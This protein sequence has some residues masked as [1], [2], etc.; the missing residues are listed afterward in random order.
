MRILRWAGRVWTAVLVVTVALAGVALGL[1]LALPLFDAPPQLRQAQPPDGSAGVAAR[2]RLTLS[3]DRPMNPRSVERALQI[4][5]PIPW[6]ARWAG[7]R[8]TLTISPTEALLPDTDYRLLLAST[9]LSRQ[10]RPLAQPIEL[11]FH[12]AQ[13]PAVVAVLPPEA[14]AAVALD[15]PISIVFSR[16]IVPTDALLLPRA[17]PELRFDPPLAGAATWL[18][19]STVLFRPSAPLRPATRYHATL[20]ATL[21]DTS[22]GQLRSPYAWSFQTAAPSVL[23]VSPADG[24]R[25][26][27]PGA[28]LA[29]TLS[30]AIALDSLRA[31]LTFS[32]TI[33]GELR[34]EPLA[35][36]RQRIT[37]SPAAA[38]RPGTAYTAT[39][40]AG[41]APLEGNLPLQ[42]LS[43]GFSTAPQPGLVARFPG[44]GQTLPHGQEIR[45]V[46]TTPIDYSALRAQLRLDP[47]AG[48]L[49]LAGGSLEVRVS[50]ELR[51]ATVYTLTV[52]AELA[53]RNGVALGQAY[54]LRFITAPAGPTLDLPEA[55]AHLTYAL[56]SQPASLLLRR[57]NLTALDIELYRLDEATLVRI[58]SFAEGDWP[59]FQPERYGQPLLRAWRVPLAD[60]L[61]TAAE[62]RLPLA[63]A[64][65]APLPPGAYYVR[66]RSLEGPRADTVLL[67]SRTR[68]TLQAGAPGS[69][70]AAALVWATDIISATPIADLPIA[71]YQGGALLH[72]ATTDRQGIARFS[73]L[74]HQRPYIALAGGSQPSIAGA[75]WRDAT[76]DPQPQLFV[77]TDR[78]AYHPGEA[79]Q[80][81]GF[82]RTTSAISPT[83]AVPSP[84]TLSALLRSRAGGERIYHEALRT[85][86]TGA[87]SATV[88]LGFD[89]RP[90]EYI[91]SVSTGDASAQA[92]VVVQ[93]RAATLLQ[94]DI[95]A[96]ALLVGGDHVP[97][98]LVVR[99][100]EGLP[101]AGATI[102]WTLS[103]TREPFPIG[104]QF[105]F[106][107]DERA[108]TPIA[109]HSA[110]AAADINGRL[111]V[112]LADLDLAD[113]PLRYRFVAQASA[114]GGAGAV[115]VA[116]LLVAPA[117]RSAG[118]RL[119]SQIF[120]IGRPG[121]VE[122]LAI[123]AQNQP[124]PG[125]PL[126]VELYRRSWERSAGDP[127]AWVP[128]D[129]LVLNRRVVAGPDGRARL[130]L[131]IARGGAYR[132]RVSTPESASNAAY[133]AASLWVSAP[134][135]TGWGELPGGG[136][137]LITD[138]PAY[139][140]GD[141]ATL[142]LI[143]NSSPTTALL[144]QARVGGLVAEAR[145]LR[146]GEPFTL[147]IAPDDAPALDLAL[148]T[149]APPTAAPAG[150]AL[151]PLPIATARLPI[152]SDRHTLQ[153]TIAS[154]RA[155]YA[156]GATATLTITTADA[157]GAAVP[158]DVV[159]A[160]GDR[161]EASA[162][163]I[164]QAFAVGARPLLTSPAPPGALV[165]QAAGLP[166]RNLPPPAARTIAWQP[167]LRTNAA[168]V[169]TTTVQ[170]PRTLG[171][172]WAHAWAAGI[173]RFGQARHS[174]AITR[175][176]EVQLL[177]PPAFRAGDQVILALLLRNN[178]PA[179][180]ELAIE[181]DVTG[182]ELDAGVALARRVVVGPG[183][184][185]RVAWP[186]RVGQAGQLRV[187]LAVIAD[188]APIE[189]FAIAE[190]TLAAL[191]V[192]APSRMLGLLREYFDT[193]TGR[194]IDLAR[195]Q[196]GQ[197]VR[198]RLTLV[199]PRPQR[200]LV[201]D[202]ALPACATL[203][204]AERGSFDQVARP[205]GRLLLTR[206]S[207][208]PG[209]VQYEYLLRLVAPG[210][211]E[212]PPPTA[213]TAA[214]AQASGNRQR[215]VVADP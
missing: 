88:P 71:I 151:D 138:R 131:E 200:D 1:R 67:V 61:N 209:V 136:P 152:F 134:G 89:V 123:D 63:D 116:E 147:T 160:L 157:A 84:A 207:L 35:D 139:Q 190:P 87:F 42:P 112:T 91:L 50:A 176:V 202:E 23:A 187:G 96:P 58:S 165:G 213:R 101:M 149:A 166:N 133:S 46:F 75:N 155:D 115:G 111:L 206:A 26:V 210:S 97:I 183:V 118:L 98:E 90:G 34:A 144:T 64:Q 83:L 100:A 204:A 28:T 13:A 185:Q 179:P 39:L 114:P 177:R 103:A 140:P 104:E 193:Q 154:D 32:P 142:L 170:L 189:S 43:W 73:G 76:A 60:P 78:A 161:L 24:E 198:A 18:D 11:R 158:A 30:Q 81:A 135:F 180:R 41:A 201:I 38:L 129:Q 110:V 146:A 107:D 54:Q 159:L 145:A 3:F 69:A 36:G 117:E 192:A 65:G 215:L 188:G 15:S 6:V 106:G 121:A 164:E 4:V 22:G 49:R 153:V 212:A 17:L 47:P 172:L 14:S 113:V 186:A 124:A 191:P 80:L 74:A 44:E 194:P 94:I 37:L 197:I 178:G 143:A 45:L 205:P 181:L 127:P 99:G 16:T 126:R 33:A 120:P 51:A 20:A 5:P 55:P 167:R 9:A 196:V 53:D 19:Q 68:L 105:V 85:S 182:L 2:T 27:A 163:P 171:A 8:A 119:P 21:S 92:P 128:R 48:E 199:S 125:T 168:G 156:P 52:P 82:M 40:Q 29:I 211:F 214:G 77:A 66:L 57:T 108:Q 148:V 86:P 56:P 137:L 102:S 130:P 12:T 173:D 174:L 195:L 122:L 208:A 169:L 184:A 162:Q 7:D 25:L 70:N 79:L 175:E 132:L 93:P 59:G 203:V 109:A 141:T 72:Q 95:R 62:E 10:F 31:T 150:S